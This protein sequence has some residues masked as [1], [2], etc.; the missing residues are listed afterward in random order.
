MQVIW[1]EQIG[2]VLAGV[3]CL[4]LTCVKSLWI[5]TVT[6]CSGA[7]IPVLKQYRCELRGVL[8]TWNILFDL[9][10]QCKCKSGLFYHNE[11]PVTCQGKKKR[12]KSELH[13]I[14]GVPTFLCGGAQCGFWDQWGLRDG[15]SGSFHLGNLWWKWVCSCSSILRCV[16]GDLWGNGCRCC[17]QESGSTAWSGAS[18]VAQGEAPSDVHGI[19]R[20]YLGTSTELSS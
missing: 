11:K 15:C 9:H 19:V 13:W 18:G 14:T 5:F 1:E 16:L 20:L 8:L 17:V 4:C 10:N 3:I 2:A 6:D 12:R 7:V